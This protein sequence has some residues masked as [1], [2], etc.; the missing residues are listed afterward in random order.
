MC[1]SDLIPS[2]THFVQGTNAY[3]GGSY[4]FQYYGDRNACGGI[5][6]AATGSGGSH[7]HSISGPATFSGTA[8]NLAVQYV[9]IMIAT[10][11]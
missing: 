10:K 9:D 6:T 2:H 1:S 4:G 7:S 11:N 3:G 5:N 8:I